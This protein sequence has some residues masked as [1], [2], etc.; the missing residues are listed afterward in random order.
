MPAYL[1]ATHSGQVVDSGFASCYSG[2]LDQ[3]GTHGCRSRAAAA[4]FTCS[5]HAQGSEYSHSI[6]HCIAA[7]D[8]WRLCQILQHM[9]KNPP[10]ALLSG[11]GSDAQPMSTPCTLHFGRVEVT[12]CMPMPYLENPSTSGNCRQHCQIPCWAIEQR[13][14]RVEMNARARGLQVRAHHSKGMLAAQQL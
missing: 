1:T 3:R 10:T 8:L 14:W 6:R 4:L 2:L 5:M 13:Q 11:V 12:K 7:V 9:L